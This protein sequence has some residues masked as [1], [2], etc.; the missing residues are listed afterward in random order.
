MSKG[1]MVSGRVGVKI[2]K[3]KKR[4]KKNSGGRRTQKR[5]GGEKPIR[6]KKL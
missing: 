1:K 5:G 4:G 6:G 3:G 2:L